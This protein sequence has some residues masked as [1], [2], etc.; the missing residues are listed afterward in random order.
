MN[1]QEALDG[2]YDVPAIDAI[3]EI[4]NHGLTAWIQDSKI[5]IE[6]EQGDITAVVD[7]VNGEV[8]TKPIMKYLGY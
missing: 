8:N 2:C 6:D 3:S 5:M 4:R 7:V 1:L